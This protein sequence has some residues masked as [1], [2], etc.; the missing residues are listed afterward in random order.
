MEKKNLLK[1]NSELHWLLN[2]ENNKTT[3]PVEEPSL[4]PCLS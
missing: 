4:N 1:I 3:T 2:N